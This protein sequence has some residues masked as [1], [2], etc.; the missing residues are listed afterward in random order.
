MYSLQT[1]AKFS[2]GKSCV[3]PKLPQLPKTSSTYEPPCLFPWQPYNFKHNFENISPW[4]VKYFHLRETFYGVNV[5]ALDIII[6]QELYPKRIFRVSQWKLS[7]A[8]I[9]YAWSSILNLSISASFH[10]QKSAYAT[11]IL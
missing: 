8:N 2:R 5:Y 11:E 6:L 3:L 9:A 7:G 1:C 4:F 10:S